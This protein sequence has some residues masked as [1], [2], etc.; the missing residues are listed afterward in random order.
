MR[1]CSEDHTAHMDAALDETA[2]V[3]GEFIW[4]PNSIIIIIEF[5]WDPNSITATLIVST[6]LK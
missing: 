5:I 2:E 6:L 1:S 4:G 3:N